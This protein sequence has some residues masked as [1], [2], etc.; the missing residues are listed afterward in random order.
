MP[1]SCQLDDICVG[2]AVEDNVVRRGQL[3]GDASGVQVLGLSA[4]A[5]VTGAEGALDTITIHGGAGLMA[6]ASEVNGDTV[7]D[8]GGQH[9]TLGGVSASALSQD[10]FMLS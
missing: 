10:D 8:L 2:G 9:I 7:F 3:V 5:T 1:R 6:H 4:H